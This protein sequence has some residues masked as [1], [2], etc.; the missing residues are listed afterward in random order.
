MSVG[1]AEKDE[2][3]GVG[4]LT[5]LKYAAKKANQVFLADPFYHLF[6]YGFLA[7]LV[8]QLFGYELGWQFYLSMVVLAGLNVYKFV[9]KPPTQE[10]K[11]HASTE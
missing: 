7:M 8:F 10:G 3:P 2:V 1:R 4:K 9:V 11:S 5:N 6:C